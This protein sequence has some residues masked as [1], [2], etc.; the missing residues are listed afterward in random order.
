MI[1]D[2]STRPFDFHHWRGL[3][4]DSVHDFSIVLVLAKRLTGAPFELS[5]Q[6]GRRIP[7][8]EKARQYVVATPDC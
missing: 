2:A 8:G 7:Q 4:R 1:H 3:R 6:P 5:I